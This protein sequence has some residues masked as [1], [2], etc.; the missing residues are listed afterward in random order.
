M[1]LIRP[2]LLEWNTLMLAHSK[3]WSIV[4]LSLLPPALC[5]C[6][7]WLMNSNGLFLFLF[8]QW[9]SQHKQPPEKITLQSAWESMSIN[10]LV[11]RPETL[12]YCF[13]NFNSVL[14][15]LSRPIL[16]LAPL[17][18]LFS[19]CFISDRHSI[20]GIILAFDISIQIF[21]QQWETSHV[22]VRSNF[23]HL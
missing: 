4:I 17:D 8:E 18:F 20:F 13:D 23:K 21:T 22:V 15:S 6:K 19:C 9:G 14:F 5:I 7:W 16:Q 1:R 2:T 3:P 10:Y 12:G 11:P